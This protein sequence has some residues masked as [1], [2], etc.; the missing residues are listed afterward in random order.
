MAPG[1]AHGAPGAITGGANPTNGDGLGVGVGGGGCVGSGVGGGV[2]TGLAVV[3]ATRVGEAERVGVASEGR[4][5]GAAALE[6]VQDTDTRVVAAMAHHAAWRPHPGVRHITI[7]TRMPFSN[8]FFELLLYLESA[9]HSVNCH[10]SE[11]KLLQLREE[12]GI[13]RET[14]HRG[15]A[16]T[17]MACGA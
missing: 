6:I 3:V 7:I 17:T 15:R 11:A 9:L 8:C 5:S 2:G 13:P 4:G 14:F 16:S 12:R 1:P 10:G